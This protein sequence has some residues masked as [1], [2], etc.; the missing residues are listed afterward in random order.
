VHTADIEQD[1]SVH[2]KPYQ[3]LVGLGLVRL[4]WVRWGWSRLG[5]VRLG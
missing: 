4:G 2:S 3:V 5:W 1:R